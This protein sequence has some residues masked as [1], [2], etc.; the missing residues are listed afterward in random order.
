MTQ[1]ENSHH[2]GGRPSERTAPVALD[3]KEFGRL[4]A[5]VE[6]LRRD[7]DRLLLLLERLDRK[8]EAIESKLAEAR[9]GWRALMLIGGASAA[10]GGTVMGVLQKLF[11]VV[12]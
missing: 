11:K 8:L 9:G 7:N 12:V 6:A 2:S 10:L 3:P 1:A 4:E 5:E